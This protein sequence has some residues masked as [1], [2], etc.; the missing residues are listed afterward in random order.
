MCLSRSVEYDAILMDVSLPRMSGWDVTRILQNEFKYSS[1]IV[2]MSFLADEPDFRE[3][4][5]DSGGVAVIQKPMNLEVF[6]SQLVDVV[7]KAARKEPL[8]RHKSKDP[9]PEDFTRE[10]ET[11]SVRKVRQVL[12]NMLLAERRLDAIEAFERR[13]TDKWREIKTTV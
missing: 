4:C 10:D 6:S 5:F 13:N 2:F 8:P 1:P 12:S 11:S 3:K 7:G 9:I